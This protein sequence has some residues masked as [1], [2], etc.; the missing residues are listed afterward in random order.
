MICFLLHF[1]V[2]CDFAKLIRWGY[3]VRSIHPTTQRGVPLLLFWNETAPFE[4][5]LGR[6][7]SSQQHP[8]GGQ[9]SRKQACHDGRRFTVI[10]ATGFMEA[11]CPIYVPEES[12]S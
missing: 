5:A 8:V 6:R 9:A 1:V 4:P 12:I 10:M 3:K 2:L 7:P 11:S